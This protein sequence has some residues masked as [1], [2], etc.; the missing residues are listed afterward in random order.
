MF[1]FQ[2]APGVNET[3]EYRRLVN[4]F[5]LVSIQLYFIVFFP[6]ATVFLAFQSGRKK[7][8]LE[9][10]KYNPSLGITYYRN[11]LQDISPADMSIITDLSIEKKKDISATL[12]RMFNKKIIN[13]SEGKIIITSQPDTLP[14]DEAE[15]IHMIQQGRITS[16]SMA[17]WKE[18]RIREAITKG[19]IRE[20][21][22]KSFRVFKGCCLSSCL[23]VVMT[24][25]AVIIFGLIFSTTDGIA[26]LDNLD[27][28]LIFLETAEMNV[29]NV[30]ELTTLA[31]DIAFLGLI[32]NILSVVIPCFVQFRFLG[33]AVSASRYEKTKKALDLAEKIAGLKR[34]IHEF[35]TL[36][37]KQKEE[38]FLW[39]DFLVYAVVL[40]ENDDIV[41][42][43]SRGFGI[44]MT[45]IN[46]SIS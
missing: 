36:S 13:F 7:G 44:D 11:I 39:D 18:N 15:L 19:Y 22:S 30:I 29:D 37:S 10:V 6:I 45:N 5:M 41:K 43:I 35:S 14:W 16:A 8:H 33:Y 12:L 32:L 42:D 9:R 40:E 38:V 1:G 17:R 3:A 28:R 21:P 2:F 4:T 46:A 34:F 26:F 27:E 23:S 20:C 31:R 24:I 25:A